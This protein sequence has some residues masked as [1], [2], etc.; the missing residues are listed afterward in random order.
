MSTSDYRRRVI[1]VGIA[2]SITAHPGP[3]LQ[4]PAAAAAGRVMDARLETTRLC[5]TRPCT[6]VFVDAII[7]SVYSHIVCTFTPGLCVTAVA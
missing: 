3:S 7:E 1:D 6:L 5:V 2:D 4:L